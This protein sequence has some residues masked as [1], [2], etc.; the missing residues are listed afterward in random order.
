MQRLVLG[1]RVL[2]SSEYLEDQV[3]APEK[4][5]DGQGRGFTILLIVQP[6]QCA[7]CG[8]L[9]DGNFSACLIESWMESGFDDSDHGD[10]PWVCEWC[11]VVS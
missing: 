2:R 1:T 11:E 8:T 10:D 5:Q 7:I 3:L 9:C 6:R 4:G